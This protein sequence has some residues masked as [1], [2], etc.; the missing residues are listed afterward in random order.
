MCQA[1]GNAA[2]RIEGKFHISWKCH[3]CFWDLWWP[4]DPC[5]DIVWYI[6]SLVVS[7]HLI[8]NQHPISVVSIF[9]WLNNWTYNLFETFWNHQR[10]SLMGYASILHCTSLHACSRFLPGDLSQWS[11][12]KCDRLPWKVVWGC[13]PVPW[14]FFLITS[15]IPG[16]LEP[17]SSFSSS[18]VGQGLSSESLINCT[19]SLLESICLNSWSEEKGPLTLTATGVGNPEPPMPSFESIQYKLMWHVHLLS[20]SEAIVSKK[21]ILPAVAQ[22]QQAPR[23]SE[24]LQKPALAMLE[25]LD[26]LGQHSGTTLHSHSPT[27]GTRNTWIHGKK[28]CWILDM[29]SLPNRN[30]PQLLL[31]SLSYV[32]MS[33]CTTCWR[34]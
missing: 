4:N 6:C 16:N 13:M 21:L 2:A 24:Q 22:Q 19:D 7:I 28:A 18:C 30:K 3:F 10:D 17:P 1:A 25:K 14:V 31:L 20:R 29:S 23:G 34:Y 32:Y 5:C 11:A 9:L 12:V 8:G 27:I 15:S 26:A 33:R